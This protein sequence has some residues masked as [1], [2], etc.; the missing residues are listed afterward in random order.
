MHI[1]PATP[2]PTPASGVDD[3]V[4]RT[5]TAEHLGAR[6]STD[7]RGRAPPAPARPRP[8]GTGRPANPP[9][10]GSPVI[11]SFVSQSGSVGCTSSRRRSVAFGRSPS[12]VEIKE[13]GAAA[14]HACGEQA[15]GYATGAPTAVRS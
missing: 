7:P 9:P 12:I 13:N 6:P 15:T 14:A 2:T 11:V 1:L 8:R 4:D 3:D 5:A 10:I